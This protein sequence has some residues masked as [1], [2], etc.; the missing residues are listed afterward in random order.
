MLRKLCITL[1]L[2]VIF[3]PMAEAQEMS[4]WLKRTKFSVL[5]FGD[6]YWLP[7]NDN[8][9]LTA[10]NGFWL[11]RTY[12]TMDHN[13]N[14]E[15]SFRVRFEAN[16]PGDFTSSSK[17]EPFVK[18]LYLRWTEKDHQVF[19]GISGTPI[20]GV[21][22][23]VWGYR[24]VEKTPLDLQKMG[25]SQDFGV[26]AKGRLDS[27]GKVRYHA[28]VGNGSGTKGETDTGKK[29][30][31]GLALYP[32]SGFVIEAYGD[33][34][35]RPGDNDRTVVQL[36]GAWQGDR[37]KLGAQ[38]AR[39][40]RKIEGS[41]ALDLDIVSFFGSV[42]LSERAVFLA[43]Y[44]RM[45]EA[46]PDAAKIAYVPLNPTAN[47]NLLLA[48]IDVTLADEFHLIPNVEAVF[49]HGAQGA[50]KPDSEVMLRTTFFVTF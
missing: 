48:G 5:A 29:G 16:S 15:L 46:N 23:K 30:A 34:E 9:A 47:S 28:M 8:P 20:W 39:Q 33:Y 40:H 4:D 2:A 41:A 19:L 13:I 35:G 43:R 36:F 7:T 18:D 38:V 45:F 14:E 24:Y 44:D 10:E 6:A 32:G 25:S 17:L 3:V 31:L 27:G 11:R 37:A 22:E 12:L 26:A 49:Y 50:T 1:L 42:Q 21:V